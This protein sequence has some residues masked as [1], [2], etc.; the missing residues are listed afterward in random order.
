VDNV[1]INSLVPPTPIT[2]PLTQAPA[3]PNAPAAP[4]V[5]SK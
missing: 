3:A 2:A 4:I 5:P 1:E